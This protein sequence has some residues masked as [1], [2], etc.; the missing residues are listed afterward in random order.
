M[1]SEVGH[2]ISKE[3][4]M[5]DD[6]LSLADEVIE[7]IIIGIDHSILVRFL[8]AIEDQQIRQKI[9][10]NLT[11]RATSIMHE[12]MEIMG[13]LTILEKEQAIND[14]LSAIRHLMNY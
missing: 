11:I 7:E 8:V 13:S 5:L 1:D 4:F 10:D 2:E 14:M 9:F 6:I 3:V 12:D